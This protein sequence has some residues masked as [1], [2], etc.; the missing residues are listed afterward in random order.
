MLLNQKNMRKLYVHALGV[1]M[2]PPE[3]YEKQRLHKRVRQTFSRML[4]N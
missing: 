2:L 1:Y 3:L 4:H